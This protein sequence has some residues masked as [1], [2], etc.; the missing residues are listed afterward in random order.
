[1]QIGQGISK[2]TDATESIFFA[3]SHTL[4]AE[5]INFCLGCELKSF[6]LRP[7]G[8]TRRC[9]ALTYILSTALSMLWLGAITMS[10]VFKERVTTVLYRSHSDAGVPVFTASH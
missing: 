10:A 9:L 8:I 6:G 5:K 3:S 1:M 4:P 7:F 2:A